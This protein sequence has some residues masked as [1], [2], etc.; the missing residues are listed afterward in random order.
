MAG[1]R[2]N[3]ADGCTFAE[4]ARELGA[5][6]TDLVAG[7]TAL[8]QIKYH[9]GSTLTRALAAARA[10]TRALRRARPGRLCPSPGTSG[11]RQGVHFRF[12]LVMSPGFTICAVWPYGLVGIGGWRVWRS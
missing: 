3:G 9:D 6:I 4:L 1:R 11:L 8:D 5:T 12:W 10:L 7:I 2:R